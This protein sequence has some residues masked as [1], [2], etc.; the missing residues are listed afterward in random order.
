MAGGGGGG[1]GEYIVLQDAI[2]VMDKK[3]EKRASE[4]RSWAGFIN[5]EISAF[6]ILAR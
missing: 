5:A 4:R 3:A 6:G 2:K 1:A